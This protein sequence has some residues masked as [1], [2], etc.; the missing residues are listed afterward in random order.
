M[1]L[2][3][4]EKVLLYILLCFVIMI[5]GLY[6]LILPALNHKTELEASYYQAVAKQQ[7]LQNTIDQYG[8]LDE[9]LKEINE[10]INT[11]KAEFQAIQPNED[12]DE[13]LTAKMIAYGLQPLSL[14]MSDVQEISLPVY[15]EE[16]IEG[17]D[18]IK[19][20][21][22][23]VTFAGT[24]TT[25]GQLMDEINTLPGYHI[26]NLNFQN[27]NVDDPITLTFN[28]YFME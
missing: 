9:A 15:G 4:R 12:I 13:L 17:Q 27:D 18:L 20:M 2:T 22:V 6:A 8:N 23:T 24:S 10:K 25:M 7:E 28:L 5:G 3:K 19:S 16:A 11:V 26:Q 14:T 1:K 21:Q